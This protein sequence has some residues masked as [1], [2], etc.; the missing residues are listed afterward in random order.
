MTPV[1]SKERK[2]QSSETGERSPHISLLGS[3]EAHQAPPSFVHLILAR[4]DQESLQILLQVC[5]TRTLDAES[6]F[7]FPD[8]IV[9]ARS[10]SFHLPHCCPKGDEGYLHRRGLCPHHYLAFP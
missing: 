6:L 3:M 1:R 7:R 2:A 4:A 5:I 8:P 9:V 10:S